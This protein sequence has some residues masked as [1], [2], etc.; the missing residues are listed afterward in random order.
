MKGKIL[1]VSMIIS[2]A[3]VFTACTGS[4]GAWQTFTD[5][6]E[7]SGPA[8]TAGAIENLPSELYPAYIMEGP[9]KKWG[10]INGEG[11]FVIGPEYENAADFRGSGIA[12]VSEKAG[13]KLIDRTGKQIME[14]GYLYTYDFSEGKTVVTDES[15]RSYLYGE[16]GQVLFDTEGSIDELS[17]GMAAFSRKA[18]GDK[19]LWGYID[20]EGKVV[21][22]PEYEGAQSFSKD[23]ALVR[24]SEGRFGL[25]D[26][27]GKLLGEFETSMARGLS[28]DVFVFS[29]TDKENR[30]RYGYMT[31]DGEVMLDAVYT[32]AQEFVD[33]LAIVNAARDYENKYGVINKSG[34]FVIPA[35]YGQIA[36]LGNGIYA[37]PEAQDVY[38]GTGFVKKA[39]FDRHGKQ[40]TGFSFYDLE[41]LE[42]GLISASDEKTTYLVDDKGQEVTG[43]PRAE[44][45][46]SI[47]FQ[48]SMYK[49]EVDNELYYL[50]QDGKKVWASDDTIRF[51]GGPEVRRKTFRPDR[52]MLIQYPELAGLADLK[53]QESIN[54]MLKNNFVGDGKGSNKEGDMYTDSI[55]VSFT[56][57][58]NKELL[59][60]SKGGYYYPIGA[61]HGQPTRE[62]YHIDTR[63][64]KLYTLE[65][66]F[67]AG[68]DY[69]AKLTEIVKGK[70]AR[71]NEEL[72]EQLYSEEIGDIE[73][74]IGYIFGKESLRIYFYPYAIA[75]YAAGFPEFDIGY[76]ELKDLINTEGELWNS[77]DREMPAKNGAA[78]GGLYAGDKEKV[79][80]TM[81]NYEAA[82]IEAINKNDFSLVEP[83]LY[84][85]S[86]LYA[87]Q[88]KLVG[89]LNKKQIKEKLDSYSI[90]GIARDKLD[91]IRVYV[92]ENIGIQ[93]PGKDY[94][95]KQFKWVY[96]VRYSYTDRKYQLTYIG[97]WE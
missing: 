13:W 16:N 81:K 85:E 77:F 49:V 90:D 52:C 55:E 40:L 57:E 47:K 93:Y 53:V 76:E 25:I 72:G 83:W 87:S 82:M 14:S 7:A 88:K 46:G 66:L 59:I 63:S 84:P 62:E 91:I 10:Y 29:S 19:Y 95:V 38:F 3:V 48:G 26:R 27:G 2:A 43:I 96:S 97:K 65:D 11:R 74:E 37:V 20:A 18:G 56:A 60:I 45:I 68:S 71:A 12:E 70:I 17:Y 67:K 41:R 24:I 28:E 21:I 36:D 4:K 32:E 86:S 1:L 15:G 22:E 75:S 54:T 94:T 9:Q 58:K 23:K 78:S 89:D 34:E 6:K 51:E 80:E 30:Q 79:E 5:T 39:L 35:E 31:A 92:T 33:G 73:A 42:K 50:S 61:A 64:G 8:V 69:K 44:G